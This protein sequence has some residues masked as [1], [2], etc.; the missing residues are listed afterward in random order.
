MSVPQPADDP[1]KVNLDEDLALGDDL[2]PH[3]GT[4]RA[5]RLDFDGRFPVAHETRFGV[6]DGFAHGFVFGF[7]CVCDGKVRD[8]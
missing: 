2:A 3:G 7:V 6:L 8:I 1:I 5:P 4:A